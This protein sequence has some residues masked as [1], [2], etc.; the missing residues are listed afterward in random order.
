M[1]RIVKKVVKS[2]NRNL[3]VFEFVKRNFKS[4]IKS[5]E[6]VKIA[7]K[8]AKKIEMNDEMWRIKRRR[9]R[10]NF[11]KFQTI[12]NSILATT[13]STISLATTKTLKLSRIWTKISTFEWI[14][15]H[16]YQFSRHKKRRFANIRALFD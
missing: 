1:I 2:T 9:Q 11:R 14:N 13:I 15:R 7:K 12:S 3:F 8:V 5:I 10:R 16:I 6:I 4:E